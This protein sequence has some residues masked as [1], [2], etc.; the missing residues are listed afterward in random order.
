MDN[1]NGSK[2][3]LFTGCMLDNKMQ[4][5]GHSLLN[6]LEAND[7]KI[8]IPEGQVCCGSPLLRT[9]QTELVQS[10]VDT[11][12]EQG[13]VIV[14]NCLF[15]HSSHHVNLNVLFAHLS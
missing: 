8:D 6:V 14:P 1:Y 9:G 13:L 4:K 12:K 11:N 5:I 15:I 7:I 2:V 10:L 3:A